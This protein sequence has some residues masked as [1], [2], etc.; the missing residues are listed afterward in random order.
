MTTKLC[1][2]FS[3]YDIKCCG[4]K[5]RSCAHNHFPQTAVC[6]SATAVFYE[7]GQFGHEFPGAQSLHLE[8]ILTWGDRES[9]RVRLDSS[10]GPQVKS[11]PC[12]TQTPQTALLMNREFCFLELPQWC[13]TCSASGQF[14]VTPSS[15][16]SSL[17]TNCADELRKFVPLRDRRTPF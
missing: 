5:L 12:M 4:E 1:D 14:F 13:H 17:L 2:P 16:L 3:P 15:V 11:A 7:L 10:P 6:C 9:D 8:T